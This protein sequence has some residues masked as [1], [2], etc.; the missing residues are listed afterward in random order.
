MSSPRRPLVA[1]IGDGE[2]V[3]GSGV[4][5]SAERIG[6]LCVDE[7]FRLV[8]GGLGGVMEA[9]FS[10]AHR[11]SRYQEGDT[12]AV[13]PGEDPGRANPFADIALATGLGHLRNALVAS[14]DAVIAVGGGAGT[15]S[16]VTFAWMRGRLIVALA[17]SGWAAEL[18]GRRL[19]GRV[20]HPNVPDDRIYEASSPEEAVRIVRTRLPLYRP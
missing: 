17:T 9:A 5:E 18:G 16:E 13:L 4:Y 6:Q 10:G 8:S 15:L 19:D 20:R 11:S 2:A 1:V 7:G 12:L 14:A 3:P